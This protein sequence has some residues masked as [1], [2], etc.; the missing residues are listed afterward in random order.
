MA[1]IG[2]VSSWWR[3]SFHRDKLGGDGHPYSHERETPVQIR[4]MKFLRADDVP[5]GS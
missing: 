4:E 2:A 5:D 3:T 1:R